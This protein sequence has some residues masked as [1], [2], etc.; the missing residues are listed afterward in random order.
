[1]ESLENE[2]WKP[3]KGYKF[4]YKISNFGRILNIKSNKFL[5]K[6]TN[7]DCF[8]LY[9]EG[10]IKERSIIDLLI[11]HF[12]L[13]EIKFDSN[14]FSE[15]LNLKGEKW[16][17]ISGFEGYYKVSNLGRVK[18]LRRVYQTMAGHE[19]ILPERI[20]KLQ[21]DPNGYPYVSLSKIEK[22]GNEARNNYLVHRLIAKAFIPN[23]E[24]KPCINHKNLNKSDNSIVNLEW[25]THKENIIHAALNGR[26]KRKEKL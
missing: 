12:K 7:R 4:I 15:L 6:R 8:S 17:D 1:M 5:V 14:K 19:E 13:K 2:I 9:K 20:L 18:G 21:K 3:L 26:L 25:C 11:C 22:R 10:K 16:K 24:N 23:P